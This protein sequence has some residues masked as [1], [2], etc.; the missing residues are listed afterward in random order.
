[1]ESFGY[2]R[3]YTAYLFFIIISCL[4]YSTAQSASLLVSEQRLVRS[5]GNVGSATSYRAWTVEEQSPKTFGTFDHA[6]DEVRTTGTNSASAGASMTS[7][8]TASVFSATASTDGMISINEPSVYS[9]SNANSRAFFEVTFQ[10]L[11]PTPFA[12]TGSLSFLKNEGSAR[13]SA[14]LN[15]FDGTSYSDTFNIFLGENSANNDFSQNIQLS[16]MLDPDTYTLRAQASAEG[17]GYSPVA[18]QSGS[19]AFDFDF[20]LGSAALAAV[21]VPAAAWLFGSAL[22]LLVW[23]RRRGDYS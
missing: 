9:S 3:R 19:A 11:V 7:D 15:L 4:L 21:P 13:G 2:T 6:V 10:V 1:M 17:Y 8:I 22:G 14:Y 20:L 18:I 23:M 5:Q 16:G 12:L